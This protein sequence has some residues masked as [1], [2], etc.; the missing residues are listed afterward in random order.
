[1]ETSEQ[2]AVILQKFGEEIAECI[3]G[4]H[5]S[6]AADGM[7]VVDTDGK[8]TEQEYGRFAGDDTGAMMDAA[9]WWETSE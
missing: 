4:G 5:E 6:L 9:R 2:L 1:M 3:A 8:A 7:D